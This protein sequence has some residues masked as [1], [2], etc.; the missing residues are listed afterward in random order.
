MSVSDLLIFASGETGSAPPEMKLTDNANSTQIL[1][2][3]S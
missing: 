1:H 3:S 2:P